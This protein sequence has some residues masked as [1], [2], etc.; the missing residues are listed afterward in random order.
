MNIQ[1]IMK[2]AKKIQEEIEQTKK[3][4]DN[5]TFVGKSALVEATITG[6]KKIK[7]IKISK[8]FEKDDLEV[9]EDMIV[10]AINDALKEVDEKT[11]EKMG[12]YANML[13]GF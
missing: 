11:E 12:K 1:A 13:P 2:N 7:T 4:I 10:V 3:E 6:D 8:D 5:M 9:L